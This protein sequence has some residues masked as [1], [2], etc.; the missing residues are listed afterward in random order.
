MV[1][2]KSVGW[3]LHDQAIDCLQMQVER[4]TGFSGCLDHTNI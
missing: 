4:G 3:I 2:A 1:L